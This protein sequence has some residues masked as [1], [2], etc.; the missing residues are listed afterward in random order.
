MNIDDAAF[1]LPPDER[2]A[3]VE[4]RRD[5]HRHPELAFHEERTAGVVERELSAVGLNPE[6]MAGTGVVALLDSGRPGRT[7][8]LRADLDALPLQEQ[9]TH[10][11]AS[12]TPGCMHACGHDGHT[13]ML[14]AAARRLVACR[15]VLVGRVLFVFQ[16]AEEVGQGLRAL[17]DAGLL[18]RFAPDV[19]FGVHLWSRAPSGECS[20]LPGA[21]MAAADELQVRV[22][23]R[24][25]HGAMPH[26]AADPV[27]AAAQMVL[28]LQTVVSRAVDPMA[29]AV[30]SICSV[31]GGSASN[32]I[33][34]EVRL[35]GTVRTFEPTLRA[36]VLATIARVLA[37]VAAA[38]GTR[39]EVEV[40]PHV[41][42]VVNDPV[43]A[44][45]VEGAVREVTGLRVAAPGWRIM[46]SEDMAELLSR[47]PGAFLFLG[48][49]DVARGLTAPHH[50]PSFD[51]DESVLPTGAE[52]LARAAARL[53]LEPAI[54]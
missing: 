23:G 18:D 40:V 39:I 20:V 26:Q 37:G 17:L 29:T 51:V 7:V 12:S 3:L 49:G 48:A 27:V 43:V 21:V 54:G 35:T 9:A 52:L 11:Y 36:D 10:G 32:I 33:P 41:P 16:P 47:V 19:A 2:E 42:P 25:G 5:L 24:G 45:A 1:P 30:V 50:H 53:A 6:R 34:A 38:S 13:A 28:A 44:A 8:L 22:L 15:D 4:L 31:H 14:L 46:A